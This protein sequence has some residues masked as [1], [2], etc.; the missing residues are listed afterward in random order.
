MVTDNLSGKGISVNR[1][2]LRII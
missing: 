1:L 2:P